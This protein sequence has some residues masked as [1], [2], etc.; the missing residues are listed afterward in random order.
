MLQLSVD[1]HKSVRVITNFVIYLEFRV[2][3]YSLEKVSPDIHV[4]GIPILETRNLYL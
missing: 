3:I 1:F 2:R 4:S